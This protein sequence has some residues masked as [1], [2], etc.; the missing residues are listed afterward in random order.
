[1]K[2]WAVMLACALMLS[3]VSSVPLCLQNP[4]R[5]GHS[6][7][8]QP[9]T[10]CPQRLDQNLPDARTIK[11]PQP[12]SHSDSLPAPDSAFIHRFK[13]SPKRRG[14]LRNK[15]DRKRPSRDEREKG[16]NRACALR[17]VQLKV[18]DLG[19]GYRSQEEMIF[20]YC[21]GVCV[22]SLTNYDK[23]LTSL[24]GGD[25]NT[26]HSSP[27]TACCRPVQYDDDLSFLDDNLMYHTMERHSA[28]RCGCV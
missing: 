23:I 7:C 26:L 4:K 17:Q 24:A 18:S 22:N 12:K 5:A 2:I 19:L 20:S 3:G 10:K 15:T 14:F 8:P 25:K 28:R 21:S 27:P 6:R 16:K 1:M 13:R 11:H 9:H